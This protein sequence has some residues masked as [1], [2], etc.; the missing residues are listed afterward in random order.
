M[1]RVQ[2]GNVL[3]SSPVQ[4]LASP[5]VCSDRFPYL[6]PSSRARLTARAVPILVEK[7]KREEE[8]KRDHIMVHGG[9]RGAP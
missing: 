1:E 4:H 2:K 9:T 3:F 5:T 7:L 6:L 8:G